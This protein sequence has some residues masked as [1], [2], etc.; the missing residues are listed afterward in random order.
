MFASYSHLKSI[1]SNP[2]TGLANSIL[3]FLKDQCRSWLKNLLQMVGARRLAPQHSTSRR[4]G[5]HF[6]V[7]EY[8]GRDCDISL[9]PWLG[10]RGMFSALLHALYNP[11]TEE[12]QKWVEAA[13]RETWKHIPAI[14]SHV[15]E[16]ITLDRCVQRLRKR[17]I[18]ESWEKRQKVNSMNAKM[19]TKVP[20]FFTSPSLVNFG[21]LGIADQSLVEDINQMRE[22]ENP[23][24]P[25]DIYVSNRK[26]PQAQTIQPA[27]I[28][29]GKW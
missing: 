8:E 29:P 15:A 9:I 14:K 11:S 16:E 2:L 25:N 7:Q 28:K 18:A 20:S 4:I 19:N 23:S 24:S 27:E 12:F 1:W 3:I 10:H 5:A 6:F 17:I 26:I 13:Q 22:K 21:G